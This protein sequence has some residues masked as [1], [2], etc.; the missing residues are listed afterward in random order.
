VQRGARAHASDPVFAW[1]CRD[2]L[3]ID[4]PVMHGCTLRF[5]ESVHEGSVARVRTSRTSSRR[6]AKPSEPGAAGLQGD[7]GNG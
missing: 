3:G 4:P 1:V 5:D 6:T 2:V 7:R